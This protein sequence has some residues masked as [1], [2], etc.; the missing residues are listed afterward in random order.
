MIGTLHLGSVT[1]KDIRL[2]PTSAPKATGT[3]VP[4]HVLS[5]TNG[6]WNKPGVTF[7]YHWLRNGAPIRNATHKTYVVRTQDVGSRVR[8]TVIAHLPG[9]YDGS[10][11]SNALLVHQ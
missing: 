4:G 9:W 2:L 3:P 1:L 10:A 6:T 11:L 5:T 7:T 8:A